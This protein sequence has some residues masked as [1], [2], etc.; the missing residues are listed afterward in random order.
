MIITGEHSWS[1]GLLEVLGAWIRRGVGLE[2][3]REASMSVQFT[4]LFCLRQGLTWPRLALNSYVVKAGLELLIVLPLPPLSSPYT[5]VPTQ[6]VYVPLGIE[7]R[8]SYM[9]GK[10]STNCAT[11]SALSLLLSK[12]EVGD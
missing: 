5:A 6:V 3:R 4:V 9:L 8:A 10:Y 1:K 11:P 12:W 2:E 7:P